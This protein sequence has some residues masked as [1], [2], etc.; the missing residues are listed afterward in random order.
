MFE[1]GDMATDREQESEVVVVRVIAD[2]CDEVVAKEGR[3][4]EQSVYDFNRRYSYVDPSEPT[5][6]A[7]YSES[8]PAEPSE[9]TIEG[10]VLLSKNSEA[11]KYKFPV[12]RLEPED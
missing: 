7:V 8:L 11:K 12:S 6:E 3:Y 1:K 9:L 5:V 2:R 4:G 10:R